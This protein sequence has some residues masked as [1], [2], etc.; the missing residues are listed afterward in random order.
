MIFSPYSVSVDVDISG[1]VGDSKEMT[2]SLSPG[3]HFSVSANA[4]KA[5]ETEGRT[6]QVPHTVLREKLE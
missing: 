2:A 5:T 4:M 6:G 3:W 1:I